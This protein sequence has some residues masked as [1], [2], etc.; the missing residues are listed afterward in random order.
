MEWQNAFKSDKK[1]IQGIVNNACL[2][3][4]IRYVKVVKSY[5]IILLV[6][7]FS[8]F[9]GTRTHFKLLLEYYHGQNHK[10]YVLLKKKQMDQEVRLLISKYGFYIIRDADFS[11]VYKLFGNKLGLVFDNTLRALRLILIKLYIRPLLV[12]YNQGD[13]NKDILQLMLNRSCIYIVHSYPTKKL[14]NVL[15]FILNIILGPQRIILTV[16]KY[17]RDSIR[18]YWIT[19][20]NKRYVYNI[21][22]YVGLPCKKNINESEQAIILTLGHVVGYKNPFFFINVAKAV[23]RKRKIEFIWAGD[24]PQLE[25]CRHSV[26]KHDSD[27]IKFI[28]FENDVGSLY[29]SSILYFQP[30]LLE[31]HSYS[32]IEAMSYGIPC[33]VSN[34]GGLPESVHD[35]FNGFVVDVKDIEATVEKILLLLDNDK[36]RATFSDNAI[37]FVNRKFNKAMW[38]RKMHYLHNHVNKRY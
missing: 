8:A 36:L 24:G 32:V 5:M 20:E 31:N 26:G 14:N 27:L 16:S 2:L 9:G 3:Q 13:I 30:S 34:L 18:K 33:I 37:S 38:T 6:P 29:R 12:V 4:K 35:G 7:E 19:N 25:A 21:Y 11:L 10:V 28:G 22:N 17:S 15:R 23:I 1:S